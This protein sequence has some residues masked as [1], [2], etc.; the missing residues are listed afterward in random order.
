MKRQKDA[1]F[2]VLR[3]F[4]KDIVGGKMKNN[5]SISEISEQDWEDVLFETKLP[6]NGIFWQEVESQTYFICAI[7]IQNQLNLLVKRKGDFKKVDLFLDGDKIRHTQNNSWKDGEYNIYSVSFVLG[8]DLESKKSLEKIMLRFDGKFN[9]PK[10]GLAK[11][12][13]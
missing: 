13:F 2:F 6:I 5:F 4:G 10:K 12:N 3:E 11:F 7:D 9:W 8:K 1:N